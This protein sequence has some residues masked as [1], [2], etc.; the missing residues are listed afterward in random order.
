MIQIV[1]I[2]DGWALEVLAQHAAHADPRHLRRYISKWRAAML[3][4]QASLQQ[5]S[6]RLHRTR[7]RSLFEFWLQ[8]CATPLRS[9]AP[10]QRPRSSAK[11]TALAT[12]RRHRLRD[13][14]C[15]G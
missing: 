11:P 1:Q 10:S 6:A 15:V 9:L 5:L 7:V 4:Q 3:A 12:W 2:E 8:A 14:P 13:I